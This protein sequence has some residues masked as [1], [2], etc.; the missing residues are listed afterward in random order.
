LVERS[1]ELTP[2]GFASLPR[3]SYLGELSC[4]EGGNMPDVAWSGVSVAE[5]V[6]LAEPHSKANYVR[7]SAGPYAVPVSLADAKRVL[8]CDQ[9]DGVPL[10]VDQGGPWRLVA[11]GARYFTSVKWVDCLELTA[12]V[13]DNSA[14]RIAK[15]RARA[16]A[17]KVE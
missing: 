11:P 16:R 2:D 17:V 10:G 7:V 6:A 1:L 4:A 15:A 12:D 8:I 3:V 5:L 9:L 13:P 14:E